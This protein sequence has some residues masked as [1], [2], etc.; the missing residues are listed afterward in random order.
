MTMAVNA[1]AKERNKVNEAKMEKY[2]KRY[3]RA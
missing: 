3:M 2:V 1:K